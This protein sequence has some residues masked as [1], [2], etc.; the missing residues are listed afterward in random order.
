MPDNKIFITYL[1]TASFLFE[2]EDVRLITDPGDLFTN[3]FTRQKACALD[4]IDLIAITHCDFDHTNRLKYIS[5]ATKI[6]I[7]GPDNIKAA[8][9]SFNIIKGNEFRTQGLSVKKIKSIHGLRHNVEHASFI[10]KI[11]GITICFMG[12]AYKIIGDVQDSIDMLFVAVSGI[13]SSP[14]NQAVLARKLKP[15]AVIP[16]H[17]ERILRREKPAHRIKKLLENS[18]QPIKC[19]IPEYG[20]KFEVSKNNDF[21]IS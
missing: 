15:Q 9:P 6:P 4:N 18:A 2:S 1:G 13:E 19:H 3:R 20:K 12:D 10:I 16:M 11:G 21:I 14:E 8:L 7:I 5:N 17:W